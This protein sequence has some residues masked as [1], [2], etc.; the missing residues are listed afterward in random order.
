MHGAAPTGSILNQVTSNGRKLGR[1]PT[2]HGGSQTGQPFS[3]AD[4]TERMNL[5][6]PQARLLRA[7][8]L[9]SQSNAIIDIFQLAAEADMSLL[10]ALR[11]VER[12]HQAGLVDRRRLRL[13]LAGL[14]RAVPLC[15]E[16]RQIAIAQE[17]VERLRLRPLT[18][19]ATI[20]R[21]VA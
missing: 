15:P 9:L 1:N 14:A 20:H 3:G 17:H 18:R 11:G 12:L 4:I 19:V 21:A 2:Q 16:A 5:H 13:T 7:L 8:L 6:G 10:K